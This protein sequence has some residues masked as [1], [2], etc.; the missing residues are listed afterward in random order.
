MTIL[1]PVRLG[2][3]LCAIALIAVPAAAGAPPVVTAHASPSSGAAPLDVTLTAD[4]AAA[5]YHWNLGDGSTA[6]GQTVQHTYA[7]GAWTATVTAQAADGE[8]AT[9]SV[10]VTATGV[11]L[12]TPSKSRYAKR[13]L[14][15]GSVVPAA[16]GVRVTVAGPHGPVGRATTN[17]AGRFTL[18]APV[19]YA[20]DYAARA[21]TAVS[22]PVGI[23]IIPQLQT[24]LVG[25]GARGSLYL[26]AVSVRPAD[27]GTMSIVIK[28]GDRTLVD[29]TWTRA[30]RVKLDTR[31]LWTY[32]ISVAVVPNAGY[33][34]VTHVLR[35]R[36]V[37]PTLSFG[38]Q[39][40]SVARLG[41]QL[42]ALHIAAPY[43]STFDSRMLDSVYAFE[44][45]ENLPRTGI[46][47]PTFWRRLA[48]ATIPKPRYADPADHLEVDKP[49]QVLFVVRDSRVALIV[50]VSTAGLPG[51]FTPV[52][53]F[54]II[55]KVDGFDPSPLGTLFDPMYFTG[56]Y[57]IH[58]NPSV[59]PYPASHG[60]VR[61]PMWLA[62][63]LFE[64]NPYG[65]T[66]Y[67][68]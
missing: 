33:V 26:L 61:V 40:S 11:T 6:D 8:T 4:G 16:A 37:L 42:R 55:R 20:G 46:V 27:A 17:A 41:G 43:T 51:R 32:G 31:K 48:V 7:A 52:G 5:S 66:V 25:S 21:G 19:R 67:V 35:A 54:S 65:E 38:A 18:R 60:C 13:A 64:T 22:A 29:H 50:P 1:L 45:I 53:R 15:R 36:V 39:S 49:Q 2:L 28:R 44:K 63:Q 10:T 9:S 34:A 30:V 57:A 58:G 12:Q 23:S 14:F 3:L 68:Y 62:A 24:R 59:P 56:G 47:D